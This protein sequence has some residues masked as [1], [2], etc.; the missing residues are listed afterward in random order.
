MTTQTAR[1]KTHCRH[2]IVYYSRFATRDALYAPSHRQDSTYHVFVTLDV[3][4]WVE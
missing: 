4:H 1:D 2:I 3:T